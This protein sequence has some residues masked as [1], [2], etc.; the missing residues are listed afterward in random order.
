MDWFQGVSITWSLNKRLMTQGDAAQI[1]ESIVRGVRQHAGLLWRLG[2]LEQ[3]MAEGANR[4]AA[5]DETKKEL[6][7]VE[8]VLQRLRVD[9]DI[10]SLGDMPEDNAVEIWESARNNG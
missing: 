8:A 10:H 6:A 5:Y 4:T 1:A 7:D 3:D 2:K 9:P